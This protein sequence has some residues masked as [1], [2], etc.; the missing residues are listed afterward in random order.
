MSLYCVGLLGKSST[1]YNKVRLR[2]SSSSA[3]SKAISYARRKHPFLLLT[4]V[5]SLRPA[6]GAFYFAV[7]I[8]PSC[9][10]SFSLVFD[11]NLAFVI[12][13]VIPPRIWDIFERE[14]KQEIL[15][16]FLATFVSIT[17]STFFLS[18]CIYGF[19]L[20]R[21]T[22]KNF[23]VIHLNTVFNFLV[24]DNFG[25]YFLTQGFFDLIGIWFY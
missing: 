2:F 10:S 8:A 16:P 3:L 15:L 13:T 12:L 14:L 11:S 22:R 21:W 25:V 1:Y 7:K 18:P 9:P 23:A 17:N 24:I 19:L 5:S 4:T 6:S 20:C